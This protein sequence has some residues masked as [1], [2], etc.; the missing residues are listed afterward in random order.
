MLFL[1][2]LLATPVLMIRRERQDATQIFRG[3]CLAREP[4]QSASTL[5]RQRARR[6]LGLM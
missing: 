2:A 5:T 3:V 6:Y 4:E 1:T